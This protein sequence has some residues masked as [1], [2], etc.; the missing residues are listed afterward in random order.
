ML[1][2]T[3]GRALVSSAQ[4]EGPSR[5]ALRKAFRQQA[6]PTRY[7]AIQMVVSGRTRLCGL[8]ICWRAIVS[9]LPFH[10]RNLEK[11]NVIFE[12]DPIKIRERQIAFHR[13]AEILNGLVEPSQ[14]RH[15]FLEIG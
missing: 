6:A 5:L 4:S 13:F 7:S 12:A 8:L 2:S 3:L 11:C 15:F 14:F 9:S 1:R 10:V